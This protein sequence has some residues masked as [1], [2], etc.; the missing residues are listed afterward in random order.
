MAS[1]RR[2]DLNVALDL[3]VEVFWRKGY[4]GTSIHELEAATNL[5]RPSLYAAFGGKG[6]MFLA[7]L[8]RYGDKYNAHLMAALQ[9]RVRPARALPVF[10]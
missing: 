4:A 1:Q 7:V 2:F 6:D 9:S 10:R 8:R 3:M 5:S